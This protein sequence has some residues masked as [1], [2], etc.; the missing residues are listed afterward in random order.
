[1]ELNDQAM[2]ADAM[3]RIIQDIVEPM[4]DAA[5]YEVV[6]KPVQDG[7]V[8]DTRTPQESENSGHGGPGVPLTVTLTTCI[9]C[10]HSRF[11][12]R[13]PSGAS[14]WYCFGPHNRCEGR[15]ITKENTP[16]WPPIPTWC[17]IAD[18]KEKIQ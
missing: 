13:N 7:T 3:L 9:Y 5:G 4:L 8:T 2:A 15:L 11:S 6:C 18:K 16:N 14:G 17:P 10:A 1:M 12:E